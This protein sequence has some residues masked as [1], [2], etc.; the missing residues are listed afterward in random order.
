MMN[1]MIMM[2]MKMVITVIYKISNI[3]V[4]L[5]KDDLIK[6]CPL[7]NNTELNDWTVTW[8]TL[9]KLASI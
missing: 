9:H 3:I 5:S 8:L 7:L 4:Q 2:T 1:M 6:T